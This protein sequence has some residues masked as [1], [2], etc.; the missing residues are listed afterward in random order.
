MGHES[1]ILHLLQRSGE[2]LAARVQIWLYFGLL[3]Y[4]CG[5]NVSMARFYDV[6]AAVGYCV[7]CTARL[8]FLLDKRKSLDG[9]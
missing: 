6:Y 2:E 3:S 9:D 4:F 5:C 1:N 7:L 8:R